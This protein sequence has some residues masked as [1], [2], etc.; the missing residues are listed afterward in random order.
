MFKATQL[1]GFGAARSSS[2]T[3]TPPLDLVGS[4][5]GAW[6]TRLLRT[7]YGGNCLK[8]RRSSDSTTQDIGFSGGTL[9]TASLLSFVGGGNGFIDTWY[10]QSGNSRNLTQTT[11]AN[12]PQIASSGAIITTVGTKPSPLFDATNDSFTTGLTLTTF[13]TTSAYTVIAAGKSNSGITN[14]NEARNRCILGDA[15]GYFV[16]GFNATQYQPSHYVS[17]YLS[18]EVGVSYPVTGAFA[19]RYNG[20][21]ITAYV[22]GGTG[23]SIAA[24]NVGGT[25]T[26]FVGYGISGVAGYYDGNLPELIIYNTSLS[27]ANL[28]TIGGNIAS[29]YGFT[30]TDI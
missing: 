14:V 19:H 24:G 29:Y 15:S 9:D 21:N 10:D 25:S 11:T 26:L 4:A 17:S 3:V 23:A 27:D 28:N 2:A 20:T 8:V 12:Q 6:G 18:P 30:W 5:T 7:A 22:D 13:I 1:I 16:T